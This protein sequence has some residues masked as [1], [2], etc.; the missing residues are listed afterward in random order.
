MT[1]DTWAPVD[2]LDYLRRCELARQV[3]APLP[4][5][6]EAVVM[7]RGVPK[8]LG[9]MTPDDFRALASDLSELATV[10]ALARL[11]HVDQVANE[12]G[13]GER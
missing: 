9:T 4:E 2:V 5:L 7:I 11:D 12:N 10:E 13:M 1:G 6:L 3:I 8:T